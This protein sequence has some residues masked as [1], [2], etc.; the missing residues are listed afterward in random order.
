MDYNLYKYLFELHHVY[1]LPESQIFTLS[2][3]EKLSA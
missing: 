3:L 1:H 2:S